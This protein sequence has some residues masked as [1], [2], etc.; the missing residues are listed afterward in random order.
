MKRGCLADLGCAVLTEAWYHLIQCV[1]AALH[2]S[3]QKSLL[4][5]ELELTETEI[6]PIC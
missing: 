6:K 5:L 4:Q 3:T 2:I 1:K